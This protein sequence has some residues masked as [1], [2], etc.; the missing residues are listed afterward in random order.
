MAEFRETGVDQF[1][2]S[3]A[4]PLVEALA[5]GD[6]CE[7]AA[8]LVTVAQDRVGRISFIHVLRRHGGRRLEQQ[9]V[10]EAVGALRAAGVKAI[11]CEYVPSCPLALDDTYSS[12]GFERI[13]RVV[14]GA[15]MAAPDLA[16]AE[17][18]TS[19]VYSA[20]DWSEIADIIVAAYQ[21]HPDR[22]L[23]SEV[24]DPASARTFVERAA[25]G[26]YGPTQPD[27]GRAIPRTTGYAGAIIACRVA[28]DVGFVL[29]L[30]V[31]PGY[32]RHGIGTR[33]LRELAYWFRAA[34]LSR[35]ALGVT[36]TNPARN[37]Y[38]RLGFEP[39]RRVPAYVWW[40]S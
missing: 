34:G 29:Q 8:M 25:H 12:L 5:I 28:P 40:R 22:R 36:A 30:A 33:L 31:R 39:L 35:I 16:C 21:A 27:F 1:R 23:H 32:Q 37:L 7:A 4:H 9:L 19:V 24:R 6:G 13:E 3:M 15:P 2:K 14:M 18:I 26:A 20:H 17:P 11:L 10:N 38:E